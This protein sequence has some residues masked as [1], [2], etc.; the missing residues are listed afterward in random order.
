MGECPPQVQLSTMSHCCYADVSSS[1]SYSN[2]V[3]YIEDITLETFV[4]M[5]L[6]CN[7]IFF[8]SLG[9]RFD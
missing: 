9:G 8:N 5:I 7:N 6:C 3:L 4:F 1:D 2:D